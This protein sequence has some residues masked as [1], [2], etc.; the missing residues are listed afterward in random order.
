MDAYD[1]I[2]EDI[3]ADPRHPWEICSDEAPPW[4]SVP[5]FRERIAEPVS[6]VLFIDEKSN[7]PA[8]LS[9]SVSLWRE[10][11]L[12][13]APF[14]PRS[15]VHPIFELRFITEVYQAGNEADTSAGDRRPTDWPC[16]SARLRI[17]RS[18]N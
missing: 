1:T 6:A 10:L 15:Q 8:E 9:V 11:R 18:R 16:G 4:P 2:V 12:G 3:Q 17:Q 13:L 5:I 14:A 7:A